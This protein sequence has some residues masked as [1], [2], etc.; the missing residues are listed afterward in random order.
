MGTSR[1]LRKAAMIASNKNPALRGFYLTDDYPSGSDTFKS[2]AQRG[3]RQA[4]LIKFSGMRA[5]VSGLIDAF[6]HQHSTSSSPVIA[7]AH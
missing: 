3:Q 4:L 2:V 5:S 1:G 7:G 6:V